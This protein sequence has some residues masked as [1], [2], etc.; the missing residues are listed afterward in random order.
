MRRRW[1]LRLGR[2]R[3]EARQSRSP[4]DH[5]RRQRRL[6]GLVS[7]LLALSLWAV[8]VIRL[9]ANAA[10]QPGSP[11]PIDVRAPRTLTFV[12]EL[13]TAQERLR[14]E[15]APEAVVYV[16]DPNVPIQQR[17]Q[18]AD[19]LQTIGQIRDDP[20]LDPAAKRAKLVSVPLPN[21]TLVI[22]P[23]LAS[24][25][26]RL[27][28]IVWEDVREQSL[29]L[30]DRAMIARSYELS[31]QDV[32]DLRERSLPYWSSLDGRG[33]QQQLSLLFSEAFLRP[34]RLLD[35]AATA[36]RKQELR[37]AVKPVQVTVQQGESVV[38]AGDIVTPAIEEKLEALGV[39]QADIDWLSI[40]GKGLLAAL[41]GAIFGR[42]LYKMQR[43]VWLATRPLLVVAGMMVVTALAARLALPL[44]AEWLYA[45]PLA[46]AALLLA[47]LFPRGLALMVITLLGLLLAFLMDGQAG[48]ATAL[49]AYSTRAPFARLERSVAAGRAVVAGE[50]PA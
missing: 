7:A 41:I 37:D 30:Y 31:E 3:R 8:L 16:R 24:Q 25:I 2:G 18:L 38:H 5:E 50:V 10:L 13:L 23:E 17:A 14:A 34:N 33:A 11:S 36:R 15:S 49:L 48:P 45:F 28:D 29:G 19:L 22:S 1:S 9:P 39:L 43:G 6:L 12:S 42:Y 46:V 32:R 40:G 4:A 44:G 35:E 26:G 27:S 20:S 21:S 47:T